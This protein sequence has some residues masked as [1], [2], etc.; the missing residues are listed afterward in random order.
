MCTQTQAPA[1]VRRRTPTTALH[2]MP[3]H[4]ANRSRRV[5]RQASLEGNETMTRLL[6]GRLLPATGALIGALALTGAAAPGASA[7]TTDSAASFA[8]H[9]TAYQ[10]TFLDAAMKAHPGGVRISAGEVKWPDGEIVGAAVSPTAH[11]DAV[12]CESPYV[13][14]YT[15]ADYTGGYADIPAE[16]GFFHFGE[17]TPTDEPGCD[18]GEHSWV[19]DSGYRMWLE[20]YQDSGNELCVNHYDQSGYYNEDY[21]GVDEDD[22]W[23]LASANSAAC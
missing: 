15:G 1:A 19:N 8:A 7:V 14:V 20:Q 12:V 3:G 22:A 4:H 5:I 16:Y 9:A 6:A 10:N 13:C 23:I 17:C 2:P 18:I 11:P 21:T